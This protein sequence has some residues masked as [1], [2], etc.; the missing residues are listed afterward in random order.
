M[1]PIRTA[2][3]LYA[4]AI[5]VERE[6]A[7]RYT[8]FAQRMS[9]MGAEAVAGVFDTLARMETEHLAALERRTE[10][11]ALPELDTHDYR[12]LEAG[13]PESAAV[14]ELCLRLMTPRAALTIALGAEKRAQAFFEFVLMTADDPA[15][16][17]LAREMAADE[18]E[19]IALIEQLLART[20][21][22]VV[23]WG[24]VY[25]TN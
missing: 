13:A 22:A 25:Q 24:S 8:E 3:E 7:E 15:L 17:G 14:H 1:K 20:P 10:G 6:A 12:W 9:D 4:H 16:R 18:G 21:P 5:A 19:H 23:D 11:L 2:P